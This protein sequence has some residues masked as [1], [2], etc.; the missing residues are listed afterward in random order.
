M[1]VSPS[2][3][4]QVFRSDQSGGAALPFS[5]RVIDHTGR[6]FPKVF[7]KRVLLLPRAE[8]IE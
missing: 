3:A 4:L 8:W 6:R 2:A 7:T 1:H 5:F